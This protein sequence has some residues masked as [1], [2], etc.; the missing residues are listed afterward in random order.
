MSAHHKNVHRI[1]TCIPS[2]EACLGRRYRKLLT[3]T[4]RHASLSSCALVAPHPEA[5]G[6][7]P[8]E[9]FAARIAANCASLAR[10]KS[11]TPCPPCPGN[12]GLPKD[13]GA[14]SRISFVAKSL[15]YCT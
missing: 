2:K 11:I 3:C 15:R 1:R 12:G 6:A 13:P 4:L 5:S 8:S 10:R 9:G 7:G 14:I